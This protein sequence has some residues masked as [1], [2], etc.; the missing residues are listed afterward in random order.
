MRPTLFKLGALPIRGYGLMVA[1]AFLV[2]TYVAARR[3]E[4]KGISSQIIFD[5]GLYILVSA[6]LGARIFH[7]LQ[8]LDTYDSFWDVLKLWQGG[9]AYYGGFMLALVVS[10]LYARKKKLPTGTILDIFGPSLILGVGIAR[11]GCFLAGCCFGKPTSLPWGV[12]FPEGSLPWFE[13]GLQKIHPTQLYSVLSLLC[14][15]TI[16][17]IIQ[18]HMKFSGQL[19]LF[20]VIMY[21][22]H[23]FLIDFLRYYAPE[24]RMGTLATSQ[25]MSIIG[26]VIA[27]A[28]MIA[29]MVRRASDADAVEANHP[30][31]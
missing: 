22:V 15:F 1:I 23:R 18:K 24:E 10:I 12:T 5:M 6:M 2:A 14:I 13:L 19:F 20:C 7:A 21:S 27:V 31:K 28:V 30:K 3:A 26:G 16:L 8:H 29:L 17:M 4:K 11:I 9:L 25:V